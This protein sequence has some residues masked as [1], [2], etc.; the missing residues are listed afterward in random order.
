MSKTKIIRVDSKG[1]LI[2]KGH[3][4]HSVTYCDI[5]GK[6]SI[7]EIVEVDSFKKYNVDV[8]TIENETGCTCKCVLI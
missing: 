1:I 8:S 5:I 4:K 2:E 3:K 7:V 6:R